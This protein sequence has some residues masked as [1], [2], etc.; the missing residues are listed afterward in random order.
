MRSLQKRQ[1]AGGF[2]QQ[3]LGTCIDFIIIIVQ[4]YN[5]VKGVGRVYCVAI[6]TVYPRHTNIWLFSAEKITMNND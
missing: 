2:K 6:I 3:N 4:D 5:I 1:D